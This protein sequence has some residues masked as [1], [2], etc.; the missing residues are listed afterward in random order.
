MLQ[1]FV[2]VGVLKSRDVSRLGSH[3]IVKRSFPEGRCLTFATFV[4]FCSNT[5]G[6]SGTL[7]LPAMKQWSDVLYDKNGAPS[8][9]YHTLGGAAEEQMFQSGETARP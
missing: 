2:G 6:Q 4:N 1:S 9:F 5:Q 7:R 8:V 3:R